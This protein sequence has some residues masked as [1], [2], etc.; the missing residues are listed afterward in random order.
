MPSTSKSS[1]AGQTATGSIKMNSGGMGAGV[2]WGGNTLAPSQ[3]PGN[4]TYYPNI[5]NY[6]PLAPLN[7]VWTSG[8]PNYAPQEPS[9][10]YFPYGHLMLCDEDRAYILD[11]KT[12]NPDFDSYN[13]EIEL[14]LTHKPGLRNTVLFMSILYETAVKVRKDIEECLTSEEAG[15]I[16]DGKAKKG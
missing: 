14:I 11:F 7:P 4:I 16:V 6:P 10:I 1:G 2:A 13:K 8:W 9:E 5:S 15:D 12:R 3:N